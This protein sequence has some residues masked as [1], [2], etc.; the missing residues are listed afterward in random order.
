MPT[1]DDVPKN[2][3][4][5]DHFNVE[6][7]SNEKC[8]LDAALAIA[9]AETKSAT[10]YVVK[11]LRDGRVGINPID[12]TPSLVLCRP[13]DIKDTV[14][15]DLV[16]LLYPIGWNNAG[17][18]V[19]EWLK[20]A[21]RG[22]SPGIDG[23]NDPNAFTVYAGHMYRYDQLPWQQGPIVIITPGWSVYSK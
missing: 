3:I 12:A 8:H 7:C 9:F 18:F 14:N 19:W 1:H 23:S 10:H 6:V 5:G 15:V 2:F 20:G 13:H 22:K 11:S 16:K 21:V 4:A 17:H